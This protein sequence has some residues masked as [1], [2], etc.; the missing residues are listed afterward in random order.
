MSARGTVNQNSA[1]L[2]S[3]ACGAYIIT[4]P[5]TTAINRPSSDIAISIN[6]G[7]PHHH[8]QQQY[9]VSPPAQSQINNH[10]PYQDHRQQQQQQTQNKPTL[11]RRDS[12]ESVVSVMT[13]TSSQTRRHTI[14]K[15]VIS[16]EKGSIEDFNDIVDMLLTLKKKDL[17]ICLFNKVFLKAKIKQAKDALNI[18]QEEEYHDHEDSVTAYNNSKSSSRRVSLPSPPTGGHYYEKDKTMAAKYVQNVMLAPKGSRAIPIVAP[19]PQPVPEVDDK[20]TNPALNDKELREE[21]DKFLG[22]MKGLELHQ[23]KQMLGNKLFPLV[24]VIHSFMHK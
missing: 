14:T 23:Q 5:V 15:A 8:P 4:P 2:S 24:K 16:V 18:F 13:E 20:C 10:L 9:A 3:L 1:S 7:Y 17:A 11:R 12:V 19:P 22:V 21:I 6:N